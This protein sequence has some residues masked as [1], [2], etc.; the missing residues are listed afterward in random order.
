MPDERYADSMA[1]RLARVE[2]TLNALDTKVDMFIKTAT[3]PEV[4]FVS[5]GYLALAKTEGEKEHARIDKRIDS[6][7]K[8]HNERLIKLEGLTNRVLLWVV[9]FFGGVLVDVILHVTGVK[10]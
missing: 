5:G 9:F 10:P 8:D 2:A 4:G 6:I 3:S 7:N 1:E